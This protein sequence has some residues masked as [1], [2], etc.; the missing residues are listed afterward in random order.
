M[1]F[2]EL[3]SSTVLS[4]VMPR[5]ALSWRGSSRGQGE[6]WIGLDVSTMRRLALSAL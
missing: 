6:F 3:S 1:H 4:W 2:L 5:L